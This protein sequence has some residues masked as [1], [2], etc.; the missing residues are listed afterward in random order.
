MICTSVIPSL[1][2]GLAKITQL[3]PCLSYFPRLFGHFESL[4]FFREWEDRPY[5]K[6]VKQGVLVNFS[7][8][9]QLSNNFSKKPGNFDLKV[10]T[11][12]TADAYRRLFNKKTIFLV[13]K[14]VAFLDCFLGT[15]VTATLM[16]A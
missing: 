13:E 16:C 7:K 15:N 2:T 9:Q 6:A 3:C 10:R 1:S 8:V 5:T 14:M 4:T 12:L 11:N